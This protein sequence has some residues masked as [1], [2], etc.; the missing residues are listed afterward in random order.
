MPGSSE[1]R[2]ESAE[3]A[4]VVAERQAAELSALRELIR[5]VAH[6]LNNP[7]QSMT[8]L[9][10]L[11][12]L[13]LSDEALIERVGQCIEG[14]RSMRSLVRDL[15][16]FARGGAT[17]PTTVGDVLDRVLRVASR[18]LARHHIEVDRATASLDARALAD[19][20]EI[21]AVRAA[22]LNAVLGAVHVAADVRA[23]AYA[24]SV[25]AQ[26]DALVLLLR[27]PAEPTDAL[28]FGEDH[29]LRVMRACAGTRLCPS[30]DAGALRL[31][32]VRSR[33]R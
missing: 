21:A 23:D 22:L 2:D 13:E 28:G 19:L 1:N 17:H 25:R 11:L 32:F 7:L 24:L 33:G 4:L 16:D 9:L 10:E 20:G 31:A 6:D 15:S 27:R 29:T 26:G 18:R 8:L 14:V 3:D 30:I 5:L 12:E